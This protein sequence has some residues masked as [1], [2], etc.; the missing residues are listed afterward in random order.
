MSLDVY[1]LLVFIF[2]L[3]FFAFIPLVRGVYARKFLK[4][5]DKRVIDSN[6]LITYGRYRFKQIDQFV[7]E[8]YEGNE[9][10]RNLKFLLKLMRFKNILL[11]FIALNAVYFAG[12]LI[13]KSLAS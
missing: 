5:L 8:N 7:F 6:K 9:D 12:F 2:M 3:I 1:I 4:T 11:V 10:T 13:Y